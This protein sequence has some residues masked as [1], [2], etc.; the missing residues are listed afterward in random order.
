M[1]PVPTLPRLGATRFME[2]SSKRNAVP[3]VRCVPARHNL[4]MVIHTEIVELLIEAP[5]PTEASDPPWIVATDARDV[6]PVPA[7]LAAVL[8]PAHCCLFEW[9]AYEMRF[10][11]ADRLR[12]GSEWVSPTFADVPGRFEISFA[13]QLGMTSITPYRHGIP[14]GQPVIVEVLARKFATPRQSVDFLTATVADIFARSSSLPFEAI[15]P[16]AYRVREHHRPPNLLFLYHFFRH[17]RETLIR[18]LQAIAG[19]PHQVL[20][21]DGVMVRL[22]EVRSLEHEAIMRLLTGGHGSSATRPM[23]AGASLLQRL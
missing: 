11:A 23:G 21:D 7:E 17:H 22:H 4:R 3:I 9:T 13:N 16:T 8:A 15:A 19:R 10:P 6:I 2:R 18:A 14:H 12:V 1:W 5:A 20:T